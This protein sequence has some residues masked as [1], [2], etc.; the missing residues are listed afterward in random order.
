MPFIDGETLRDKLN[1]ETQLGIEE[2]VRITTDVADA[3]DYA[4]RHN[5]RGRISRRQTA[6]LTTATHAGEPPQ[7]G[8]RGK[9]QPGS[10]T[11]TGG[12]RPGRGKSKPNSTGAVAMAA[13]A[14][15]FRT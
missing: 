7:D 1:R 14:T 11:A 5:T 10:S 9:R 12:S 6:A 3:L 4:H 13:A 2:A 15:T 8:T